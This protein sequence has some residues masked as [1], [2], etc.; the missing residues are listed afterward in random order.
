MCKSVLDKIV[1]ITLVFCGLINSHAVRCKAK[2]DYN[3]EAV[4]LA[5]Q[6]KRAVLIKI[7][8]R[9]RSALTRSVLANT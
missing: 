7:G 4:S 6:F 9:V 5:V 2:Q 8:G 3:W 1:W